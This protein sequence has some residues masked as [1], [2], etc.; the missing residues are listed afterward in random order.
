MTGQGQGEVE[1]LLAEL[2]RVGTV[3]E[4]GQDGRVRC[5]FADRDGVSSAPLPVLHRRRGD[6]DL[7]AVGDQAVCLMLPPD[8]VDGFV[9][10]VI[11]DAK[12]S[13]PSNQSAVRVL[14]GADVRLG[15]VDAAHPAPFGDVAL[16]L[17]QG[18]FDLLR[19][20]VIPTPAG[21]APLFGDTAGQNAYGS[22]GIA[23]VLTAMENADDGLAG[24]NS[25]AIKLE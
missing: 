12:A 2:V 4:V 10:G 8:L 19:T 17:L 25:S 7:P 20:A 5:T 9:L 22:G 3:A 1:E 18:I 23:A 15:S 6:Q 21:P 16:K 13:P 11:Y 24:L 14:S